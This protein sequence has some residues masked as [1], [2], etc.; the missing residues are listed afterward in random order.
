MKF[1]QAR[2]ATVGSLCLAIV[3]TSIQKLAAVDSSL[4]RIAE[5]HMWTAVRSVAWTTFAHLSAY[6]RP[7]TFA[8]DTLKVTTTAQH[9]AD[10]IISTCSLASDSDSQ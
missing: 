1:P 7:G 6:G 10:V 5:D 2:V 8:S 4:Q 9:F 3:S